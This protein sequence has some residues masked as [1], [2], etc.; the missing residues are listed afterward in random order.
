MS[1]RS[2]S[3]FALIAALIFPLLAAADRDKSPPSEAQDLRYGVILYHFF[4]QSY[5]EALTESLVGEQYNDMPFHRQSAKLLRGGMSLS[6][7]MGPQAEAIFVELIDTLQQ[8]S[9]RDRAWFY[10][11]K[12]YYLRGERERAKQVLANIQGKELEPALQ[13]E[14]VFMIANLLLRDQSRDEGERLAAAEAKIA[15]LPRDSPWLAYYY[16][17]RGSALTL[18]G[19]WQRG[20][21][22]FQR[23]GSL[24]LD[25]EEGATLRDKAF[26]ASGF[27]RLGGSEYQPAIADFLQVRLDSPLVDRALLGYGWAAAQQENYQLALS[28]WQAL[29]K[30][31]LMNSSVQESLLAIPYAYEKL[32]APASALLEY[33]RAVDT[34]ERELAKLSAAVAVFT[35]NSMTALIAAEDVLGSDWISG[36]DYLPINDQAPYLAHLISQEHFQ[37]AV[38]DLSDLNRM[39]QYLQ[40]SAERLE[41]LQSVLAVQQR[42]WRDSLNQSQ[43]EQYRQHY[44]E[45]LAVQRQ[46]REQQVI[47]EREANGRRFVNQQELELWQIAGNAQQLISS[48]QQAGE[49]VSDEQAQLDLYQGL[50][51]WQANEQDTARRWEFT[52]VLASVDELL[53]ETE[54]RLARLD[55]LN[56][57]RYDAEFSQQVTQLQQ[58]LLQQ[59]SDVDAV[60]QQAEQQ[61]RQL[62]V[63]ELEKQQQRLSYYMG[64]AKLAIARLYDAGSA[65]LSDE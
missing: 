1:K 38:K 22:S 60:I 35:D 8:Q 64:Q 54:Q 14:M 57:D 4:Q 36:A 24:D 53:A 52:K 19:D 61:L 63:N 46:L 32:E 15:E 59:R 26:T 10:L 47:A 6:Y 21:E 31:S 50:L 48:L 29:G 58:R 20:V 16:F 49:D 45:L 34:F 39:Q 44:N 27:A 56:A 9:E 18:S 3:C 41:G 40:Q 30:R 2:T 43:R 7:G 12:L 25:G 55:E 23:V 37:S 33:Q 62:A 5:F 65:E 28:P 51:Y 42:V 13:Q 11:G 17:N